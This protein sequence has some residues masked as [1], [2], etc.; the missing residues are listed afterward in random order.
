SLPIPRLAPRRDLEGLSRS[1]STGGP[2]LLSKMDD[3]TIT[4][5]SEP[6]GRPAS[7]DRH[8]YDRYWFN[9]Y[10][11]DGEFYFGIGAALYPNLEIFDCGFSIAR[12]G[13]QHP[14]HR[15]RR[16]PTEAQH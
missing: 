11:D 16:A 4:Q 3:F 8:V 5:T 15:P 12:E 14:V 1:A 7:S 6:V 13:R 9:G 2:P 10:Q